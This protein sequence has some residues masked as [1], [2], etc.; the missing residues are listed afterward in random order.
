MKGEGES[1]LQ[2]FL[3]EAEDILEALQEKISECKLIAAKSEIKRETIDEIFRNI[4]SLKGLSSSF[5][6]NEIVELCQL[7]ERILL[8]ARVNTSF[9]DDEKLKLIT[10]LIDGLY[11]GLECV[12]RD[13]KVELNL[14]KK[15]RQVAN[16]LSQVGVPVQ[17][18]HKAKFS[19]SRQI[20]KSLTKTE[21]ERLYNDINQG[22]AIF[23][24]EIKTTSKEL[25]DVLPNISSTLQKEGEILANI[26][27]PTAKKPGEI[28]VQYLTSTTNKEFAS[29]VKQLFPKYKLYIRSLAKKQ[30]L[31]PS[32]KKVSE[33]V[34][35][36]SLRKISRTLRID[37]NRL[38]RLQD[39]MA[40]LY[41]AKAYLEEINR[42]YYQVRGYSPFFRENT[43]ALIILERKLRYIQE[44]II[45]SRLV[46][47]GQIFNKL[48]RLIAKMVPASRQNLTVL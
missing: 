39:A 12:S 38:D 13:E 18:V 1:S 9:M 11:R 20:L 14:D 2:V 25:K 6:L 36:N 10:D 27:M 48:N 5:A 29:T 8:L 28:K 46:P 19:I 3:G 37:I 32:S 16:V 45:E 34:A 26:I 47:I 4:H 15:K 7:I 21:E 30:S 24:V 35:L 17:K 31:P 22:K 40:E 23:I 42:K 41:L 44:R 33:S 43:Q